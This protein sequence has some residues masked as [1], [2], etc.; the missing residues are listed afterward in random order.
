MKEEKNPHPRKPANQ[1]GD[2]PRQRDLKVTEKSSTA[3]LRR[4]KQ[5]ER[6][7]DHHYHHPPEP[8]PETLGWEL[9]TETQA[10][11]NKNNRGKMKTLRNDSQ[12]KE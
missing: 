1:P 7:T 2:Q 10:L 8:Q 12:L 11:E 3:G 4:A 9:G 5:N 6:C